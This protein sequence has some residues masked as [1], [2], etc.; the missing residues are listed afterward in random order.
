MFYLGWS[1]AAGRFDRGCLRK[2]HGRL[3]VALRPPAPQFVLACSQFHLRREPLEH[4]FFQIAGSTGKAAPGF[5][6][7]D[8]DFADDVTYARD[9]VGAVSS[10]H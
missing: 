6:W 2:W 3:G 9:R 4:K 8:C 5:R 7:V 10:A 1:L